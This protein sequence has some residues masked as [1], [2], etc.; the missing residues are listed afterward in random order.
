V[1]L[2]YKNIVFTQDFGAIATPY[3]IGKF[4][5]VISGPSLCQWLVLDLALGLFKNPG[6]NLQKK[7]KFNRN[8]VER[9]ALSQSTDE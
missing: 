8:F 2:I 4:S 3:V 1:G 9:R 6:P 7:L 5:R